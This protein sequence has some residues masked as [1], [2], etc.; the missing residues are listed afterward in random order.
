MTMANTLD[1]FRPIPF[2]FL[3]TRNPDDYTAAAVGA[4][5]DAVKAAGFGGIVFFNKPPHGFDEATY[6]S[7]FYYDV[8]ERFVLACRERD[9]ALWINDG[10]NFPPGDAAGR[11]EKQNPTLKQ[12]RIRPNAEGRLE[13]V[14]VPW[15][16]PAFE[17]EES[18]RLFREIVY[19]GH[20]KHLGH[21]F[22]NGITG[23]FSDADNRR[24]NSGLDRILGQE[25]Y[26][27]WSRTFEATFQARYGYAIT[28]HLKGLF[29]GTEPS[30]CRDFW[31]LCGELYQQWFANNAKWCM[32]NHLNYTFHTSDTGPLEWAKCHRSSLFSEGNPVSL[33][34]HSPMPGTDHEILVLDGGT[35]YDSRLFTPKVTR[36][37]APEKLWHPRFN[38][39]SHDARAKYA[40]SVAT[41]KGASRA[42]CEMF[43]AT[44]WGATYQDLR[45]IATWQI[46]QGINFIV[47][48]AVHHRFMDWS[49]FFAPPEFI[50]GTNLHGIRTFND[51]LARYCQAATAGH[52]KA[53]VALLE[54]TEEVWQ[55]NSSEMFFKLF[56]KLNRYAGG[57]VICPKAM[58]N[59]YSCVIDSMAV[60]NAEAVSLPQVPI[61]FSGGDVLFMRRELEDGTE[62]LLV[63]NVW[64]NET[65][66]GVLSFY[67][68]QIQLLLEPG[69]IAVVGGPYESYR[70]VSKPKSVVR[71]WDTPL[72]V[73]WGSDNLVPF[74]SKLEFQAAEPTRLRLHL[75][76]GTVATLDGT[77][78]V[79]GVK[80]KAA[81][82]LSGSVTEGGNSLWDDDYVSYAFKVRDAAVHSL[83]VHDLEGN[84]SSFFETPALLEGDFSVESRRKG[85]YA[86]HVKTT[87]MLS[88][89]EPEEELT[90]LS[91]RTTHLRTDAGWEKQGG[92]FYSGTVEYDL[93]T[94]DV[95][96]GDVLAFE[97]AGVAEL[98]IDDVSQ[99]VV[100]A[101]PW[102][103]A[104]NLPSGTHHLVLRCTN[105]MANRM[106][107]YA[108]PSGLVGTPRL[109]RG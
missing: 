66:S 31:Q 107:R 40:G 7:D 61:A 38:D 63:A 54:P 5:M 59:R 55:G 25:R 22:G 37:A 11:I 41:L 75:P 105:T 6:L 9:L 18:S 108:A 62:Y 79:N 70:M 90:L 87:Y 51:M 48:H 20:K 34:M 17:E 39:T 24:I 19:E 50:H 47:P 26:Y 102:Q 83:K 58:A 65:L 88:I 109:L 84:R 95:V 33:L 91:P 67:G 60:A 81:T 8:L 3:T 4:A 2:Y 57:Y 32:A 36:G 92:L 1:S 42:M 27:P 104:L 35:H 94:L 13:V 68:R 43:A 76:A 100:V 86:R 53:E 73:R 30:V 21:Y 69:E 29:G 49:K 64:S 74:N 80:P 15:G 52:L 93:G 103:F 85:D 56:D 14:E 77:L 98:I 71:I 106:E 46:M 89:Y 96:E 97:V 101:R 72:P 78:L 82:R 10:F 16:F 99:G 28:E 23:F 44:N 12:Q 45:R